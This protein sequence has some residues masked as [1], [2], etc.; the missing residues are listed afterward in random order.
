MQLA[1]D[2]VTLIPVAWQRFRPLEVSAKFAILV[3]AE[4]LSAGMAC[5]E[6]QELSIPD[7]FVTEL[8]L[9]NGTLWREAQDVNM[10]CMVVTELVS[11]NGTLFME[12]QE[13]NMFTMF[14]TELVS[15]NGTL[16]RKVQ[17]SNMFNMVVVLCESTVHC[18]SRRRFP[19]L[20]PICSEVQFGAE[21]RISRIGVV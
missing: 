2:V 14:V 1:N 6:V 4:Q 10:F 11:N 13:R 7:M 8:V 5:R 16:C 3:L 17:D 20:L 9:N 15:N 12:A 18:S 21:R 19:V